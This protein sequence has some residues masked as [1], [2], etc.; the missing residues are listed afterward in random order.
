MAEYK[1]TVIDYSTGNYFEQYQ[2]FPDD[3]NEDDIADNVMSDVACEVEK[4]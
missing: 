2:E 1:I 3:W 4:Q